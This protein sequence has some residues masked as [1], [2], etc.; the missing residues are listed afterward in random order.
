MIRTLTLILGLILA[1]IAAPAEAAPAPPTI[2][3]CNLYLSDDYLEVYNNDT[4]YFRLLAAGGCLSQVDDTNGMARVD[5]DPPGFFADIDSWR[6][7]LNG[8]WGPC[9]VNEDGSSNPYSGTDHPTTTYHT[10]QYS[11][12]S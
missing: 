7:A 9:Y 3:V 5:V 2:T 8:S 6:K 11:N 1:G 10:S 12:C 4:G